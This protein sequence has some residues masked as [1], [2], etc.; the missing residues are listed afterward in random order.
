M[1]RDLRIAVV[2]WFAW[3][4]QCFRHRI[5]GLLRATTHKNQC[6][7][8]Q[9]SDPPEPY[10]CIFSFPH[11]TWIKSTPIRL[12]MTKKSLRHHS[13]RMPTQDYF[14]AVRSP[15]SKIYRVVCAGLVRPQ[16]AIPERFASKS[17]RWQGSNLPLR[18]SVFPAAM[19]PR[20]IPK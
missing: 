3:Q 1:R 13:Q 15:E 17:T 20:Q 9:R 11:D 4:V 6:C 18:T 7:C 16:R 2:V 5:R 12:T 8:S 10:E 19:P 14:S